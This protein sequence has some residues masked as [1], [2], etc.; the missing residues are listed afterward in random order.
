MGKHVFVVLFF[1][2]FIEVIF[3]VDKIVYITPEDEGGVCNVDGNILEP[4]LPLTNQVQDILA[5]DENLDVKLLFLPGEYYITNPFTLSAS[6]INALRLL[7]YNGRNVTIE[8]T[9]I[10]NIKCAEKGSISMDFYDIYI[11]EVHS[12]HITSCT[13][14][15]AL[16]NITG[17]TRYVSLTD[18]SLQSNRY[19]E[20][21]IV[22]SYQ[23]QLFINIS[24]CTF[25]NNHLNRNGPGKAIL[26][27]SPSSTIDTASIE[28]TVTH[29]SFTSND[30]GGIYV[31]NR[32]HTTAIVSISIHSSNFIDNRRI[33]KG[34]A[35]SITYS[36]TVQ[37]SL[38]LSNN[39]FVGNNALKQGGAIYVELKSTLLATIE[40]SNV[41]FESNSA[42]NGGALYV[43]NLSHNNFVGNNALKQGGAI[44]VELIS[45]V[46]A[47][48]ELSDTV[49]ESNSAS[50]GGA[51]Y[52]LTYRDTIDTDNITL[53]N[54]RATDSGGAMYLSNSFINTGNVFQV[55]NNT[56]TNTGGGIVLHES[57]LEVCNIEK[58][59]EE[60]S[61][62]VFL[63]NRVTASNGKGGAIFILAEIDCFPIIGQCQIRVVG[64]NTTRKYLQFG[65]NYANNGS[66]LYGGQLDKCEVVQRYNEPSYFGYEEIPKLITTGN[67]SSYDNRSYAITSEAYR[68]CFCYNSLP[69]CKQREMNVTRYSGQTIQVFVAGLDQMFMPVPTEINNKY[70]DKLADLDKGEDKYYLKGCE[71]MTLHVYTSSELNYTTLKIQKTG[72]CKDFSESFIRINTHIKPCPLGVQQKEDRCGCDNRLRKYSFISSCDIDRQ[73][74]ITK[75]TGWLSYDKTHLRIHDYCPLNFCTQNKSISID[76]PDN[77]C[78]DF[79]SGVL[80]GS[81]VENFSI[82]LGSW[83][84][85]TCS[86]TDR[87]NFIWLLV[88]M[89]IAGIVLFF[90]ISLFK[91]TV[92]RGTLNGLILYANVISVSG[93][94][95]LPGCSIH[96]ILSVFISWL[97]LD[98]GIETCFFSGMD[99]YLKTWLQFVF[100]LY[101][102]V[103]VGVIIIL[104]HYSQTAMKWMGRGNIDVLATFFLLSYTKI[105]KTIITGLSVTEIKIARADNV[106]DKLVSHKVWT[107]DGNVDYL[108][109]KHLFL[110]SVSLFFLVVVCLPYTLLLTFG[111][112]LRFM[113]E[114]KGLRWIIRSVVFISIMDAY[115]APYKKKYRFWTGLTLLIRCVLFTL[116]A[117]NT[118]N[119]LLTNMFVV[120]LITSLLLVAR[121]YLFTSIYH[122]RGIDRLE[123]FF[124]LNLE[125]LFLII[126]YLHGVGANIT[127]TCKFTTVLIVIT[128]V[129]FFGILIYHTFLRLTNTKAYKSIF[130]KLQNLSRAKRPASV[131]FMELSKEQHSTTVIELR[132]SLLDSVE[133]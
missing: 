51:L 127:I 80:C 109:G 13:S 91:L 9:T 81:C 92:S 45:T 79:H 113:N 55:I 97:N 15:T 125:L 27:I 126:L 118:S 129:T 20:H 123:L 59:Q 60:A 84:C 85:I 58:E 48:I 124:L 133:Q 43:L 5:S 89:A 76:Q 66:I 131:K 63:N 26:E 30:G 17:R 112:Y 116:F 57:V 50:N 38:N 83:R 72:I 47:T 21:G 115:H 33:G 67:G 44:Y 24:G 106:S 62:T 75:R 11:L 102:W 87:Y 2:N 65:N 120:V 70:T 130:L 56:A 96:P 41:V 22:V 90:F 121:L 18:C 1:F 103:L 117:T 107:Y 98:L 104:C 64:C 110:F 6:N 37:V 28:L 16:M 105:L 19:L 32:Y 52:V 74:I 128:F 77:Q 122:N 14:D 4:C 100:P 31:K 8:S 10:I 46:L 53:I 69:E 101:I 12:L 36:R 39:N 71:K 114:R 78:A 25:K 94:L 108:T 34:G 99:A 40:L 49:F 119:I 29:C 35:I 3:M 68:L 88:L 95:N 42:T 23:E 132:E 93:L 54:N 111:Q 73:L 61:L 7:L 82:A 86:H